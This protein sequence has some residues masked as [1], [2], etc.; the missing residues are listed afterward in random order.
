MVDPHG[1]PSQKPVTPPKAKL[2]KSPVI[3]STPLSDKAA[4]HQRAD[5]YS[6][7]TQFVT[8]NVDDV[9]VHLIEDCNTSKLISFEDF[10]IKILGIPVNWKDSWSTK[11]KPALELNEWTKYKEAWYKESHE[12][13]LYEPFSQ[14]CNKVIATIAGGQ[15]NMNSLVVYQHDEAF[16]IGYTRRSPDTAVTLWGWAE[17]VGGRIDDKIFVGFDEKG[18]KKILWEQIRMFLEI[19]NTSN[20]RTLGDFLSPNLVKKPSKGE[21]SEVASGV[22]SSSGLKKR[23]LALTTFAQ[24]STQGSKTQKKQRNSKS[25]YTV[26]E[27]PKPN[28]NPGHVRLK[29]TGYALEMLTSGR[30]RSHSFGMLVDG[31]NIQLQYYDRSMIVKTYGICLSDE[32]ERQLF[33]AA[34]Y[35]FTQFTPAE[36]GI[37]LHGDDENPETCV[38][39]DDD[40]EK[41]GKTCGN[42]PFAG[43]EFVL[44]KKDAKKHIRLVRLIF[45]SHGLIGRGTIVAEAECICGNGGSE[46]D[47]NGPLVV[48][49]SFPTTGRC[50]E[51]ELIEEALLRAT[52]LGHMWA[53]RHLPRILSSQVIPFGEDSPQVQLAKLFPN[54]YKK[55][56]ACV[57]VQEKLQPIHELETPEEF[58]QVFYDILQCHNWVYQV[59]KILH[60]DISLSNMMFW[61]DP[62]TR[63]V[64]GVLN[65]FDL[66]SRVM[67]KSKA[68][69]TQRTGTQPFMA[70]DLFDPKWTGGHLYRHDLESIFYGLLCLCSR[71]KGPGQLVDAS[72]ELQYESWFI[73][74]YKCVR[75]SK[76]ELITQGKIKPALTEFFEDFRS[77][78]TGIH[79]CIFAGRMDR[80]LFES[81]DDG[82]STFDQE[83]LGGHFTYTSVEAIMS[84]FKGVTLKKRDEP[85]HT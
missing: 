61:R 28:N 48:K 68:S 78:V 22:A 1:T 4:S 83:T 49:I 15:D 71:Y 54:E 41:A 25:T 19:K 51:F 70:H 52:E 64:F 9:N 3:F 7:G 72:D 62:V 31:P 24:H 5:L 35:R 46:C 47:W 42:D 80:S 8:L 27:P 33:I 32:D 37:L 75:R 65:D 82:S 12:K 74:D 18:Y 39:D 36:W 60:R 73:G 17:K 26:A 40:N 29:C 30:V 20:G 34:L 58:A 14:V 45:R 43:M 55:R 59:A 77:W 56:Y 84:S 13:G 69:S 16:Q 67:E 50:K 66:S 57:I 53:R 44:K 81:K 23:V 76:K 21:S 11:L 2:T 38:K 6:P 63:E 85:I 79:K 10:A